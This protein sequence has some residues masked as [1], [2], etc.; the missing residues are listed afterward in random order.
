MRDEFAPIIEST[1]KL[2]EN[3]GRDKAISLAET[4]KQNVKPGMTIYIEEGANAAIREIMRQFWGTNPQFTLVMSAVSGDALDLVASGL[5][6]KIIAPACVEQ[7]PMIGPSPVIQRVSQQKTVEIEDWSLYSLMLRLMAGA[8]GIGFMPTKSLL[9]SSIA[10]ANQNS[11][12]AMDDPFGSGQRLGLVKALNPDLAIVHALVADHYGNAIMSTPPKACYAGWGARASRGG[13]VLTVEK[14]VSTDYIRQHAGLVTLPGQVIN[15]VSAA[16]FGTHPEGLLNKGLTAFKSYGE[17]HQFMD[18][19]RKARRDPAQ[20]NTRLKEWVLD[21]PSHEAYL[22]KLGSARL[23][24]LRYRAGK[25]T[26]QKTLEPLLNNISASPEYNAIEMMTVTAARKVR[27][28]V[29]KKGYRILLVGAGTPLAATWLAYLQLRD[30]GYDVEVTNGSGQF[31]YMPRPGDPSTTNFHSLVTCKMLCD[32]MTVYGWLVGGTDKSLAVLGGAEI[33]KHGNINS[34]LASNGAHLVGSGGAN[35]AGN[36]AECM[37]VVTQSPQRF[38]DKVSYITVPGRKITTLISDLGIFEKPA[39]D[40]EFVLTAYFPKPGGKEDT[41]R[42]IKQQCGWE[43][44]VSPDVKQVDP[45]TQEEL[46]L[47]RLLDAGG[48]LIRPR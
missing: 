24:L 4:I 25:D 29:L 5:V 13:V 45:P 41:L 3:E 36:A 22:K 42:H 31:G 35:D 12:K 2:K 46:I 43:L 9:G 10:E 32:V 18:E 39:P 14:L 8:L 33:D 30:E 11:F 27:E 16:R 21:C 6:K 48:A 15:S 47:L 19:V 40:K 44:K 7:R 26:W 38:A 23:S 20:L 28:K 37:L 34:T 1:F 17:D